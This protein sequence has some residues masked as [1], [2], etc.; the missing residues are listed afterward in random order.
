M[1]LP[2][3]WRRILPRFSKL[4]PAPRGYLQTG[5][6]YAALHSLAGVLV[7][8]QCTAELHTKRLSGVVLFPTG[9]VPSG[10]EFVLQELGRLVAPMSRSKL[11]FSTVEQGMCLNATD[12]SCGTSCCHPYS[13]RCTALVWVETMNKNAVMHRDLGSIVRQ[14]R[15]WR[16]K[17]LHKCVNWSSKV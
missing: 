17:L 6:W 2:A 3:P 12:P 13:T 5:S 16:Q 14:A 1:V 9:V 11:G 15:Q 8:L 7:L 10:M 4:F